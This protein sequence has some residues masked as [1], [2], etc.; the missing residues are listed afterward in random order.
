[1]GETI[2]MCLNE[3]YSKVRIVKYLSENFPVHN[4]L[5]QGDAF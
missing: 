1:M 4:G 5:K 2:K 3:T